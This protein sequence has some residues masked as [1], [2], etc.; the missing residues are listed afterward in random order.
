MNSVTVTRGLASAVS[1]AVYVSVYCLYVTRSP[2]PSQFPLS[3]LQ[4]LMGALLWRLSSDILL[5]ERRHVSA[6]H[7]HFSISASSFEK[8][9]LSAHALCGVRLFQGGAPERIRQP[10]VGSFA[11]ASVS[12]QS[13]QLSPEDANVIG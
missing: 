4:G 13:R 2:L 5:P 11:S 3:T 9:T 1:L 12:V 10:P 8:K 6:T 7:V